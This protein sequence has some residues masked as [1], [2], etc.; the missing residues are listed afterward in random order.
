[1]FLFFFFPNWHTTQTDLWSQ[2]CQRVNT[3]QPDNHRCQ[4]SSQDRHHGPKV[5]HCVPAGYTHSNTWQSRERFYNTYEGKVWACALHSSPTCLGGS[6]FE[7]GQWVINKSDL[8]ISHACS[9]HTHES[10]LDT[11]AH[12]ES[13]SLYKTASGNLHECTLHHHVG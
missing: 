11:S 4:P 6:T 2:G 9:P 13:A 3:R 12:W 8:L 7:R 10:K 1:M 5:G